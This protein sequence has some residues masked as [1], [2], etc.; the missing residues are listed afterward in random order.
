MPV[1]P[2]PRRGRTCTRTLRNEQCPSPR[3]LLPSPVRLSPKRSPSRAK[4]RPPSSAPPPTRYANER[5]VEPN[6]WM[7]DWLPI[8]ATREGKT[9]AIRFRAVIETDLAR[10]DA[11]GAVKRPGK[12]MEKIKTIE[13][14]RVGRMR[15][16]RAASVA[17]RCHARR[18]IAPPKTAH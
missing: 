12:R 7:I 10:V 15:A 1:A 11:V 13:R 14:T 9:F 17:L 5:P 4:R 18:G 6:R 3:P 2:R 16:S 8:S